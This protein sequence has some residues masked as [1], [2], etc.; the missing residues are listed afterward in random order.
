[1][2]EPGDGWERTDRGIWYRRYKD[3][4]RYVRHQASKLQG[5]LQETEAVAEWRWDNEYWHGMREHIT[6]VAE[7]LPGREPVLCLGARFGH[8]VAAWNQQGRLSVGI[9]VMP[10]NS[11][12][13]MEGDMQ[14]ILP[15]WPEG[16]FGAVYTNAFDH[17]RDLERL[18]GHVKRL[19]GK[20]GL[21][22]VDAVS[23][24]EVG[25]MPG[26]WEACW[27]D[28]VDCLAAELGKVF[29]LFGREPI[30]FPWPGETLCMGKRGGSCGADCDC[31]SQGIVHPPGTRGR[32][33]AA[34]GSQGAGGVES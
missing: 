14:D 31:K 28:N 8:E 5:R 1:M 24:G 21:F 3:N 12:W 11:Y 15:R 16:A 10:G 27:W 20:D 7:R 6:Q 17:S 34:T 18:A 29:R 13:V 4:E 9:D 2:I 30:E 19:L 22:I 25:R 26:N 33:C 23:T 32:A